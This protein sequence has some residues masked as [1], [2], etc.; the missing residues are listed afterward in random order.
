M[1]F[2]KLAQEIILSGR[3]LSHRMG[4][5]LRVS[6]G[7]LFFP[8]TI[9]PS[10]FSSFNSLSP[11]QVSHSKRKKKNLIKEKVP[12][13]YLVLIDLGKGELEPKLERN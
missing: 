7:S 1:G 11:P 10:L 5:T 3:G 13:C 8:D 4:R 9:F 2:S 12:G 6:T